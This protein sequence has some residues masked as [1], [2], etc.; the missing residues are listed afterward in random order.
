M[1]NSVSTTTATT[2]PVPLELEQLIDKAKILAARIDKIDATAKTFAEAADKAKAAAVIEFGDVLIR[3]KTALPHG[4]WYPWLA[5]NFAGSKSTATRYMQ[6]AA[7]AKRAPVHDFGFSQLLQLLP[8]PDAEVENFIA[9]M[10]DNGTPAA[11]LSKRALREAVKQ[12]RQP[13][14]IEAG[15]A[16][17]TSTSSVVMITALPVKVEQ[18]CLPLFENLPASTT[19]PQWQIPRDI[20]DAAAKIAAPCYLALRAVQNEIPAPSIV[21]AMATPYVNWVQALERKAA[22]SIFAKI[23]FTRS[24][25]RVVNRAAVILYFGDDVQ[26]FASAFRFFGA[27][28]IPLKLKSSAASNSEAL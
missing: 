9:A 23:P 25:E 2:S 13:V 22:A 26:S 28:L 17:T 12:W 19:N 18:L 21:V 20:L 5:E 4:G 8:L 3:I 24:D 7:L 27:A 1:T 14:T 16:S 10:D 15:V 6:C 11:G